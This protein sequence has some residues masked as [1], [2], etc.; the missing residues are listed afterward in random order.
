MTTLPCHSERSEES[1]NFNIVHSTF[2]EI[3]QSLHSFAMTGGLSESVMPGGV[4]A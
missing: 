3:P 4:E 2:M 1:Q